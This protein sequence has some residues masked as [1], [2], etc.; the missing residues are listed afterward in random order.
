[1][2]DSTKTVNKVVIRGRIEDVWR[3][4]TKTDEVQ[5]VMFN[6]RCDT[7]HEV[8]GPMR[9]R[10]ANGKVTGVVGEILE[11][12]PPHRYAHTFKFTN[13]DDPPCKV[14]YDLRETPEGVEFILT[15]EDLVP[16]S[17]TAKQM[18]GGADMIAKNLKSI[19]ETGRLPFGTR[20]LYVL[21]R[22]MAP[23]TPKKCRSENW[24]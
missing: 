14:S 7:N 1:M 19:V 3:E 22:V 21:F 12:D 23:L 24:P 18:K 2:S 6:M 8:G 4:I 15:C 20:M 17:R 13:F 5:K 9:M 11:F 10:S 16:G